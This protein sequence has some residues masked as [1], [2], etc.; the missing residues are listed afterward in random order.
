MQK[1]PTV[2]GVIEGHTDNV[3]SAAANMKLSQRRAE[4]VRS[5]L[6]K[7]HGIAAGR[8]TAKGYGMTRPIA[9]NGTEAGRQ[10]NRRITAVLDS[11]TVEKQ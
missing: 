7:K 5:Y 10:Q 8:L 6:I 3:G 2:K 1:Y 4:A 11:V 9:D